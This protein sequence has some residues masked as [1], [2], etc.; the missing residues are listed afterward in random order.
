MWGKNATVQDSA[1]GFIGDITPTDLLSVAQ[2]HLLLPID[3]PSVVY[4]LGPGIGYPSRLFG[5]SHSSPSPSP[6]KLNGA[7]RGHPL[8]RVQFVQHTVQVGRASKPASTPFNLSLH[9][10]RKMLPRC[11]ATATVI[12]FQ[13]RLTSLAILAE[14]LLY[15]NS[16]NAKGVSDALVAHARFMIAHDFDPQI[17]WNRF[18]H[19]KFFIRKIIKELGYNFM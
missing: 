17:E 3:L 9:L 10:V 5:H 15:T 16:T 13:R 7:H 1:A 18:A 14:Q 2:R 19:G 11:F 6:A 8:P 4:F 12:C